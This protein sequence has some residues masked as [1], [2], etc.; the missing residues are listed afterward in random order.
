MYKY[1]P[2]TEVRITTGAIQGHN[3]LFADG[4]LVSELVDFRDPIVG[5]Q[6]GFSPYST[7]LKVKDIEIREICWEDREQSYIPEF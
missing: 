5:G 1:T 2:G 4:V 6:V 7:V 3:F